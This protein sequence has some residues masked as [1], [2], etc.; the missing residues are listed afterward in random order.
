MSE[1]VIV[2][3]IE[4]GLSVLTL[5]RP[6][7]R[8]ALSIAL[9][10][11]LCEAIERLE[12]D[13]SQRVV[14]LRGA[15]PVFSAGLDLKEAA[16]ATLVDRSAACVE[17]GLDALRETSLVTI[18]AVHGGAYAGGAGIMAA[19]DLAI[20]ADD[21]RIGFPEARRGLLPA[22]I[23]DVLRHKVREGELRELFLVG[24]DISATQAQQWGIV[25][26]VVPAEQLLQDAMGVAR[27]ILRGGPDTIRSTKALINSL[28]DSGGSTK[29]LSE[30]HLEA[31]HT[32]EAR[33]GLAAFLEK[34][35]P[36]WK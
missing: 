26:R 3:S 8:N 28:Y 11:A 29:T 16:D 35:E 32:D 30:V 7:R 6:E 18:A 36:D 15:G 17:R 2:E 5:N 12:G 31:R 10:E 9:L 25:Q 33:E 22:L 19:C 1:L 4:R 20:A 34:R 24:E 13:R 23:C 27:A 14:I 21:A